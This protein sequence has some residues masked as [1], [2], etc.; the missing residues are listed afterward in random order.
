MLLAISWS[1]S[2]ADLASQRGVVPAFSSGRLWRSADLQGVE[3]G[4][5]NGGILG[6]GSKD[7]RF[8]GMWIGLGLAASAIAWSAVYCADSDAGCRAGQPWSGI[9][10]A[11]PVLA[12]AGALIGALFPKDPPQ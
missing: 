10:I 6:D 7:H 11:L 1:A 12:G 3:S 4:P 2:P 5:L 9:P 8:T